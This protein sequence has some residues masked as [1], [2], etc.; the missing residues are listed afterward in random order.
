[1]NT[2]VDLIL[3]MALE[4]HSWDTRGSAVR[5]PTWAIWLA[6]A[7]SPTSCQ[8]TASS[9]RLKETDALGSTFLEAHW[10]CLTATDFLTVEVYTFR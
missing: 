3:R 5:W 7:P 8:N 9:R 2:I 4:N 6:G 10:E 1:M